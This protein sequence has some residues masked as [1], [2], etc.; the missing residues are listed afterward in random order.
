M[1][2]RQLTSED[3]GKLTDSK[4]LLELEWPPCRAA[5]PVHVDARGYLEL[6]ARGRFSDALDLIREV[7][8]FPGVCGRICHHPCEQ[9]CRR[10]D[11]DQ[12]AA[13]RDLKR[14][15]AERDYPDAP[16]LTKPVQKGPAVAVIGAGPAGLSCALDLAQLGYLPTVFDRSEVGGG[17]LRTAIPPYRLPRKVLA[18][19]VDSILAQGVEFRGGVDVGVDLSLA[20][21]RAQ[22]FKAIVLANGLSLSRGLPLPGVEAEGVLLALPFLAGMTEESGPEVGKQVVVIGGGNVAVDVARSA[23]RCGGETVRMACLESKEEQPAWDWETHEALEEG[24]ETI[25]RIGPKRILVEDGRVCG[26]E[27]AKVTR[28]FDDQGRFNPQFDQSSLSTIECQTVILAIGQSADLSMLEG[29]DVV[30]N[31]GPRLQWD[32]STARTSAK[33]VFACG[34]VITGPGSAVEAVASGHRTAGAVDAALNGREIDL[35]EHLPGKTGAISTCVSEKLIKT[36]RSEMPVLAPEERKTSF[37]EFEL[38]LSEA[39]AMAEARRCMNCSS[40]PFVIS[41]RCAACLTC[42]RVCPFDIPLVSEI[43][44]IDSALCQGCGIC[45]AECPGNAIVMAGYMLDDLRKDIKKALEGLS[46]A[47]TRL[48]VLVSGHHAPAA[49]WSGERSELPAGAREIYL[50]SLTRLSA[51]EMLYAFE[52]GADGLLVLQCQKGADRY[53]G[54]SQRLQKRFDQ[55]REMLAE[56]GADPKRMRLLFGVAGQPEQSATA[57]REMMEQLNESLGEQK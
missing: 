39:A 45:A 13:I 12:P 14:F 22:G 5:C 16:K 21:L 26:V 23:V 2:S 51:H 49:L 25:Y 54:V 18:A 47:A 52:A 46:G 29:S 19:D 30:V 56:I 24:I 3:Y 11:V 40:G 8:P 1:A 48:L 4:S 32:V 6:V 17:L 43:A 57:V 34:E 9:D 31:D 7:L 36:I 50:P 27:F 15:V 20:D 41:D 55:A 42:L 33:D 10:N 35:T 38:G 37:K 44:E 53:P 28:V